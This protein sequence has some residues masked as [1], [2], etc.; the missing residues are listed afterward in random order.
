MNASYNQRQQQPQ[1]REEIV[2]K[3]H[4]ALASL[5][6]ER[7]HLHRSKELAIE[8]LRLA[9]EER[10]TVEKTV[11]S[12]ENTYERLKASMDGSTKGSSSNRKNAVND[13]ITTL[14]GEVERLGR[15]VSTVSIHWGEKNLS[16]CVTIFT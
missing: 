5:R 8:R 1:Q 3:L 4:G 2:D 9:R 15:E 14:Q 11:S 13:D 12:M 7:D 6:K 10:V 16:S